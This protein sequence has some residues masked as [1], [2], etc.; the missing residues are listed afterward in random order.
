M[1]YCTRC[2]R[3]FTTGELTQCPKCSRKLL[4]D[5]N[6]YSPV[7]IVTANGFELERIKAALTDAGIPF[8]VQEI[9]KDAGIQILN[10]APPENCKV[11]VPLDFYSKAAELLIG[12]GAISEADEL[13]EKDEQQLSEKR[14]KDMPEEMSPR[15]RFWVRVVSIILF[16]GLIAAT[17]FLADLLIPFLNPNY[18]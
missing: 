4:D 1:K 3:I 8:T 16:I 9:R 15:K 18:H 10:S 17:V 13:D 12:I 11:F 2:K 6:H 7:D 5:P 14:K